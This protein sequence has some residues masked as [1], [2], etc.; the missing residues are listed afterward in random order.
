MV[1]FNVPLSHLKACAVA[2]AAKDLRHDLNGVCIEVYG[3]DYLRTI[4]TDGH[5]LIACREMETPNGAYI[6]Q[7][8]IPETLI[9]PIIK[10]KAK[11][12]AV[13]VFSVNPQ[14]AGGQVTAL[15]P[16]GSTVGG[17]LIEGRYPDADRVIPKTLKPHEA[18]QYNWA[19]LVDLVQ[20]ANH[21]QAGSGA[22]Q[23]F[24]QQGN[25]AGVMAFDGFI[26]FVMPIRSG[27]C[28]PCIIPNAVPEPLQEAA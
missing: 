15:M 27:Y 23:E 26:G 2:M 28:M 11:P 1:E 17:K 19:Y 20:A 4:G 21:Y 14:P 16:D 3:R 6:E 25:N 8:I 18:A 7:Y 22:R 13:I 9:K 5:R 24:A 10:G 12:G